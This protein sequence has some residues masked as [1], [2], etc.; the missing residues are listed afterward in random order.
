GASENGRVEKPRGN[1][2]CRALGARAARAAGR[3]GRLGLGW[4]GGGAGG[5]QE[6]SMR[7]GERRRWLLKRWVELCDR[8][9]PEMPFESADAI[10]AVLQGLYA[11]PRRHYHGLGHVRQ[12]LLALDG[13]LE[14]RSE[15]RRVGK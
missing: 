15:E 12:C 11:C 14:A 5:E 3:A 6:A 10:F 8:L 1:R 13:L 4:T 7:E 9:C 2:D